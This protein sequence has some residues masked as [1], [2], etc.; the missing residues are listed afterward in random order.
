MATIAPLVSAPLIGEKRVTLRGLTWLA[1]QQ[2]LHAL[3]Q[4][5]AARLTYDRGVLEITQPLEDHEF[6]LRLIE[7]F[8]RI[9][10]FEMGMKIKTMGSTTMS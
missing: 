7:L 8:I 9:L 5:R 6:S 1:Y 4:N 10:A 3:P 2:V